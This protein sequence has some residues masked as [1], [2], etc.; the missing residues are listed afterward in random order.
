MPF[1]Q[2]NS[3]RLYY[4]VLGVRGPWVAL[5][6]GARRNMDEMRALATSVAAAGF[7]VLLHDRRNTG[8][9]SLSLDGD[10]S[11]FD[12]WADDLRAL[13]AHLGLPPLIV[14]GWS[15]GCRLA[16]ITAL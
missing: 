2:V 13:A 14:G 16:T 8:R 15:S 12:I 10:G 5:V 1:A 7:R 6:S 11:E 4:Q 9:S 3:V